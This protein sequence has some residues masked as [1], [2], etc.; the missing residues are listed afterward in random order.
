M[1]MTLTP[2]PYATVGDL[3]QTSKG[4][5][6]R[7]TKVKQVNYGVVDEDGKNWN[8]RKTGAY[9][10]PAGAIFSGPDA[11]AQSYRALVEEVETRT[12]LT[13]GV[14]VEFKPGSKFHGK[15]KYVIIRENRGTYSLAKLNGEGGRY[16]RGASAQY[17]EVV[18]A[19]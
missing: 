6:F 12:D 1:T 2:A 8:L 5:L 16:V 19:E 10:A 4:Q 9:L 7:V 13:V 14:V 17:L 3:I 11:P 15:G 18:H